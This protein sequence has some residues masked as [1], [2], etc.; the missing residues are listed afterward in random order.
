MSKWSFSF[1]RKHTVSKQ[2]F[3]E[4]QLDICNA[5]YLV[6]VVSVSTL[7]SSALFVIRLAK[8]LADPLAFYSNPVPY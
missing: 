3:L 2:T 5:T 4:A 7:R 8:L 6:H 1:S